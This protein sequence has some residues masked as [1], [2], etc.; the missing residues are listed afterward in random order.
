MFL[1]RRM[2]ILRLWEAGENF[3]WGLMGHSNRQLEDTGTEGNLNFA[4]LGREISEEKSVSTWPRR[5]FL[6][7]FG[8]EFG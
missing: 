8:E 3:Q 4:D 2:W 7:Y 6:L 1:F 5:L